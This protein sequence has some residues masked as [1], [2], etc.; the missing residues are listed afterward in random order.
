[1]SIQTR[2]DAAAPTLSP[3]LRRIAAE[4]RS[5]PQLVTRLSITDLAHRCDTSVASVVRFCRAVGVA[6]YAELRLSLAGEIG[7]ESAQFARHGGFGSEIGAGDSL[8][9]I[10]GTIAALE[11]L[12][13]EET[14]AGLDLAA[15]EAVVSA[16]DSAARILVFGIGA[17]RMAA[18]DL[19]HKLLRIGRTAI[20]F[21]DAHEAV[22]SA[23]LAGSGSLAIGFSH[24]GETTETLRFARTASAAGAATAAVTGSAASSLAGAVDH[25]LLTTAREPAFR[26]GAMVSRI[27]QLAVVDCLFLGIAQRRYGATIE[28]LERTH[29]AAAG[30]R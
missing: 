18:T 25:V 13:I 2:I 28:A 22:A 14:V 29:D 15:L 21:A 7:R 12:A 8:A 9:E 27:A 20:T 17:S 1:M 4:I 30:L 26:A 10:T 5:D 6:G 11:T 24:R 19:C 23:A 3:A 16:A